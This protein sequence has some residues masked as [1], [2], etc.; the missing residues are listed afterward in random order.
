MCI[1]FI[2]DHGISGIMPSK[3]ASSE[4]NEL[5]RSNRLPL[6]AKCFAPP[7]RPLIFEN[8]TIKESSLTEISNQNPTLLVY[9]KQII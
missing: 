6:R 1:Y 8:R 5:C 3:C 4:M 9:E 2:S 7:R